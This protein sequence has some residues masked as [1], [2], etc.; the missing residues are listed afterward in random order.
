MS[1]TFG[2]KDEIEKT[3]PPARKRDRR[4]NR[5]DDFLETAA[6]VASGLS[7]AVRGIYDGVRMAQLS[8]TPHDVSR[9]VCG[10]ACP[11]H[12]EY[13]RRSAEEARRKLEE[14]GRQSG[15]E[16]GEGERDTRE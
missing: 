8:G 7:G 2:D 5:D 11:I 13:N 16:A 6:I 4:R 15:Q 1:S 12:G 10:F 3:K 9:C 14:H